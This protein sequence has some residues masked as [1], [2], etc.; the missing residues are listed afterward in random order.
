MR[1]SGKYY[2]GPPLKTTTTT[3]FED[4]SVGGEED[5]AFGGEQRG[6]AED[7]ALTFLSAVRHQVNA[8]PLHHR[9]LAC[10]E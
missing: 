6:T 2:H 9:L 5:G 10:I 4:D 1:T 3:T 7:P 8:K